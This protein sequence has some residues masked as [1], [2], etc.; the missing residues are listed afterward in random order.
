MAAALALPMLVVLLPQPASAFGCKPVPAITS[1]TYKGKQSGNDVVEV[2][3]VVQDVNNDCCMSPSRVR[4]NV[5]ITRPSGRTDSGAKTVSGTPNSAGT[6]Q[7][8]PKNTPQTTLIT[9]P[10]GLLE[11]DPEK[12]DASLTV[13][14]TEPLLEQANVGF[15]DTQRKGNPPQITR[16]NQSLPCAP[17]VN[18]TD[19]KQIG[20]SQGKALIQ[21]FYSINNGV[22]SDCLTRAQIGASVSVFHQ[23]IANAVCAGSKF[24]TTFGG[25][26]IVEAPCTITTSNPLS[27]IDANVALFVDANMNGAT[28]TKTGQF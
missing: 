4:I 1:V 24:I 5:K 23:G 22:P 26:L 13:E 21:V 12:Y 2:K 28:A 8:F 11:R 9:I 10:R 17:K 3:W 15:I 16:R 20:S 7:P 6:A 18:I 25:D 27:H 19:V 14:A